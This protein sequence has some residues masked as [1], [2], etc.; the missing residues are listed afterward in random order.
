MTTPNS[1][2]STTPRH[3]LPFL[4]PGQAQREFFVNES[5]ARIDM[6]LHPSVKGEAATPPADPAEG[7]CYVVASA[8]EGDWAGRDHQ[9]AGWTGGGWSFAEPR[10][11]MVVR[12]ESAASSLIYAGAWIRPA[13]PSEPSGGST[14]DAEARAAIGEVVAIL[15]QYGLFV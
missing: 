14:V 11:G 5:L 10:E 8:A 12:D 7:D 9:L 6:L 13:P 1:F 15:R 3:A 2:T 4:F